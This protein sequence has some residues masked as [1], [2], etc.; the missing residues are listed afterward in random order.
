M[1]KDKSGL[2]VKQEKY[3]EELIKGKTQRDAYKASYNAI[4]MKDTTV[5]NKASVLFRNPKVKKRYMELREKAVKRAE[6]DAIITREEIIKEL[7]DMAR[8]KIG[9][10]V[11]FRTEKKITHID[12]NGNP[13]V[14][15]V[16]VL[17]VKDSTC[18]DTKNIK[19]I[20]IDTKGINLKMYGRDTALFKLADMFGIDSLAEDKQKLARER[21]EHDKDTDNKKYW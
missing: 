10:V 3:V 12:D 20:R 1:R 16:P 9:D 6:K 19:E 13:I 18:I 11:S 4:N 14:E 7:V 5:D 8:A 2:T 17:D 21:F 15:Y